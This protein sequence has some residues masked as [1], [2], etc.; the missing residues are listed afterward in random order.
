M[1]IKT[2]EL[3]KRLM[4]MAV[5]GIGL[6]IVKKIVDYGRQYTIKTL[7]EYN[8]P[9][10][11]IGVSMLDL[12]I[13][14]IREL[15]YL[16]DWLALYGRDGMKD[17]LVVVIDKPPLCYATDANTIHCVNFDT[18]NVSIK[19]DGKTKTADTDYTIKGTAEDFDIL[20]TTALS[21]GAHDLVIM[22]DKVAWSG[23]IYV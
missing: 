9:A 14:K 6:Y 1:S 16:G 18:T 7:K 10:I 12:V 5:D 3:T 23:K 13:P 4:D 11:K 19:I 8:D 20:L 17:L 21:S 2:E 22:G 15:P